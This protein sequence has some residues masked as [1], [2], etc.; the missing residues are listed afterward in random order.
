MTDLL[1]HKGR[2]TGLVVNDGED[3]ATDCLILACGQS[4]DDTYDLLQARACPWNPNRL[5]WGFG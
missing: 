5:P 2:L 3:I 1:I 4:G